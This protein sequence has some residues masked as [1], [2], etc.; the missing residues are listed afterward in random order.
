MKLEVF[1]ADGTSVILQERE[2]LLQLYR[3]PHD[4]ERINFNLDS[5]IGMIFRGPGQW[6]G[7]VRAAVMSDTNENPTQAPMPEVYRVLPDQTTPLYDWAIQLWRDMN[8]ELDNIRF[9][10]LLDN[11]L[12]LTNGT[13]WPG[14]R[15]VIEQ[16]DMHRGYPNFHAPIVTGGALFKGREVNGWLEIE[17][18]RYNQPV[19]LKHV[20]E[21][22]WLWFYGTTVTKSGRV[23][24]MVRKNRNGVYVPVKVPFITRYPVRVPLTWLHKLAPGYIPNIPHLNVNKFALVNGEVT[25]ELD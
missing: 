14:R 24:M 15:N 9:A 17:N 1:R 20:L 10:S 12:W 23:N 22:P 6:D 7:P 3:W 2:E 18:I 5:H 11:K 21:R 4:K 16:K 25:G 8:N 13:G 19:T